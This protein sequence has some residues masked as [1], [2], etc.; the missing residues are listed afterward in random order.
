MV[1]AIAVVAS[2]PTAWSW[3]GLLAPAARR[4]LAGDASAGMLVFSQALQLGGALALLAGLLLGLAPHLRGW[5]VRRTYG[6]TLQPPPTP[7]YS[8]I[9][10]FVLGVAPHLRVR[11]TR[12]PVVALVFPD[13]YR[14]ACLGVGMG[15][16]RLWLTDRP[17]AEA[18]LLHEVAHYR[19]GDALVV[20]AGSP[21]ERG[22]GVVAQVAVVGLAGA[23][24]VTLWQATA[25]TARTFQAAPLAPWALVVGFA[26]YLS[27]LVAAFVTEAAMVMANFGLWATPIVAA[28][29][30]AELNADFVAA[31]LQG[32]PAG[33]L[34]G[35]R[36]ESR[37]PWWRRLPEF[38]AHPPLWLRGRFLAAPADVR[39]LALLVA[40]PLAFLVLRAVLSGLYFGA[41]V[42]QNR[43]VDGPTERTTLLLVYLLQTANEHFR[44]ELP[45]SAFAVLLWP[46]AAH[47][48]E[49]LVCRDGA[50][51]ERRPARA[52]ALA[53]V[54]LIVFAVVGA[55]TV[56]L[57]AGHLDT[58]PTLALAVALGD[59]VSLAPVLR[60]G[61]S[62]AR[63]TPTLA[64]TA[65]ERQ[66]ALRDVHRP[67]A[68]AGLLLVFS[69]VETSPVSLAIARS[70]VSVALLD[71][72]GNVV[73][74]HDL[75]AGVGV[76]TGAPAAGY[77]FA[78][79]VPDGWFAEA[80]VER[81]Q[82]VQAV[83]WV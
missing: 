3:L 28:I 68:G 14:R 57:G 73:G 29:W 59:G 45:L 30:V 12:Q 77:R 20:G 53:F 80:G 55:R 22:V 8:E 69:H 75:P 79:V 51:F 31:S 17:S 47:L 1:L 83:G 5:Y 76:T 78:L 54:A 41:Q 36:S 74:I 81:G 7:P 25:E 23:A 50:V 9:E 62:D 49:R 34:G 67:S 61:D 4:A 24:L 66:R 43:L 33:V 71:A 52:N 48:W 27:A 26:L 19:R 35:L 16:A 63:I 40:Y 15:L 39:R 44:R 38:V 58:R 72:D 6:L 32:S 56:A 21:I 2:I 60:V 11:F 65:G 82:R 18:A 46:L 13:G 70:P 64:T 10:A 42:L 37:R